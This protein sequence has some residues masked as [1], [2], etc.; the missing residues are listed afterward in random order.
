MVWESPPAARRVEPGEKARERICFTRPV[1]TLVISMRA[2][3]ILASMEKLQR[4]K[5]EKE[6]YQAKN[7][8]SSP[9]HC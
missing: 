4:S 1:C 6:T 5:E 7:T 8:K 2:K 3:L 9:Y